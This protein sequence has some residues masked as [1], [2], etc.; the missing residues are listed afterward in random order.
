MTTQIQIVLIAVGCA[1]AVG[2]AGMGLI[3]LLRR[4]SLRLDRKSVV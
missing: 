3:R 1:S 2:L 4:A